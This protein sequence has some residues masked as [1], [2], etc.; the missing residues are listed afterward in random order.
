[1][2]II[3]YGAGYVFVCRSQKAISGFPAGIL[4][5]S[6]DYQVT[7]LLSVAMPDGL[8]ASDNSFI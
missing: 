6:I 4:F 7:A 1:L 5:I 3:L 2:I 8:S